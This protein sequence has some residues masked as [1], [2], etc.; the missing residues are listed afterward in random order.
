MSIIIIIFFP[1]KSAKASRTEAEQTISMIQVYWCRCKEPNVSENSWYLNMGQTTCQCFGSFKSIICMLDK[2]AAS[3]GSQEDLR[4]KPVA[5]LS[6]GD[7]NSG[8]FSTKLVFQKQLKKKGKKRQKKKILLATWNLTVRDVRRQSSWFTPSLLASRLLPDTPSNCKSTHVGWLDSALNV[9]WIFHVGF[10]SSMS[11]SV[12][13]HQRGMGVGVGVGVGSK[14]E[15]L[16]AS[17]WKIDKRG[18]P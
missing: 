4:R 7:D 8:M 14:N 15:K 2:P 1:Y 13:L 18:I 5:V 10:K 16:P 3:W 12:V 11:C 17:T 6:G 9:F